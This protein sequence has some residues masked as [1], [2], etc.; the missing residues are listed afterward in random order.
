MAELTDIPT[1]AALL[2][3]MEAH[4]L[5][6]LEIAEGGARVRLRL[7]RSSAPA[8]I[9]ETPVKAAAIGVFH[10][11]YPGSAAAPPPE[12]ARVEAGDILGFLAQGPTLSAV[13]APAA[14]WLGPRLVAE[15]EA[16]GHGAVIATIRDAP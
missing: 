3:R 13:R 8:P 16:V 14:G 6:E 2:A 1:L 12:G 4:G 9:T 11:I 15:G 5:T 7:P 10:A